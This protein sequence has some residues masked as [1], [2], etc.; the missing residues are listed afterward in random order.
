MPDLVARFGDDSGDPTS[1]QPRGTAVIP[2]AR[3]PARC[4][5]LNRLCRRAAP[6]V[7]YAVNPAQARHP[8][9]GQQLRQRRGIVGLT[10]RDSDDQRQTVAVHERVGLGGQPAAGAPDRVIVRFVLAT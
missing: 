1:P 4:A 7:W 2:R 6:R 3:S 5:V 10:R 9:L 8:Q